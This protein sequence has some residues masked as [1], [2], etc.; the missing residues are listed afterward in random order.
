M[1]GY[2]PA[3]AEAARAVSAGQEVTIDYGRWPNDVYLLFYG[4]VPAFNEWDSVVLFDTLQ[5]L[6]AFAVSFEASSPTHSALQLLRIT[7]SLLKRGV[8][9]GW[10]TVLLRGTNI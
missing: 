10:G 5:D 6:V 4:F 1:C 3:L 2:N 9:V 8:L 7:P